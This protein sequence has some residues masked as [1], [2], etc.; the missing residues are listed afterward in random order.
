MIQ[1]DV[2]S[3]PR[4]KDHRGKKGSLSEKETPVPYLGGEESHP[5]DRVKKWPFNK[6]KEKR[7]GPS[8]GRTVSE[9]STGA[10][11]LLEDHSIV[12]AQ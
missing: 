6:K 2:H 10:H 7:S 5:A 9:K 8:I 11:S 4:G 12:R 3:S 1:C